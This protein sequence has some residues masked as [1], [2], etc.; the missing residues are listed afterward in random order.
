MLP[1]IGIGIATAW[2]GKKIYDNINHN[3]DEN[4]VNDYPRYNSTDNKLKKDI[5]KFKKKSIKRY[6]EKYG[7]DIKIVK[8]KTF[9]NK[10]SISYILHTRL[11]EYKYKI[12]IINKN[13]DK[14]LQYLDSLETANKEL[15]K[16]IEELLEGSHE[17]IK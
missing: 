15:D 2:V 7:I 4:E 6:K 1:L 8:D 14:D 11:N 12:N 13:D 9:I 16:L 10:K 17:S 3:E 5:K